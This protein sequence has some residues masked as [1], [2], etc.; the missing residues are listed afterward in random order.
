MLKISKIVKSVFSRNP[1]YK[2]PREGLLPHIESMFCKVG[3]DTFESS[4]F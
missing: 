2:L 3:K 1:I 4:F